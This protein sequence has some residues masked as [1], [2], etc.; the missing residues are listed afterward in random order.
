MGGLKFLFKFKTDS[1]GFRCKAAKTYLAY[2]KEQEEQNQ[3][4]FL[5]DKGAFIGYAF[6]ESKD[7][8]K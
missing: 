8:M 2:N 4:I 3:K 6:T 5:L 1:E 7:V